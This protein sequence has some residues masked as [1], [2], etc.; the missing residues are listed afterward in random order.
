MAG[1]LDPASPTIPIC[2]AGAPFSV[3]DYASVARRANA[4]ASAVQQRRM[5]P[6]LPEPGHGAFVNER[7][8]RDD[9][10]A[11][12]T[13]WA[14]HGAPEGD[15]ARTP[16][17]PSFPSGWQLGT[18]DLVVT[19]EQAYTLRPGRDDT[20]R[21]FVLPVPAGVTR[22]VRGIEFR[23]GNDQVLHHANVGLDLRRAGRKLDR[24]D[25]EPGFAAMPE[26]QVQDVYGWSPGQGAADGAGRHRVGARR[27]QRPGR[28]AAHGA[29]GDG[30][31]R[32]GPKWVS[33]FRTRRRRACRL[34]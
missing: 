6:W 28:A 26:D 20:F 25:R 11:T 22:Y 17:P 30:A 5:P 18:P 16:A 10:I 4:I 31:D 7:R 14:S 34:W 32:A 8:L 21:T 27:R 19:S 33:T 29:G 23:A 24:A 9:E 13:A 15:P 1:S 3:L 12:I 2:V